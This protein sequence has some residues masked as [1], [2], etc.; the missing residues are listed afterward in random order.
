MNFI[1]DNMLYV[2]FLVILIVL[3]RNKLLA[4]ITIIRNVLSGKPGITPDNVHLFPVLPQALID[5]FAKLGLIGL[6]VEELRAKL[7]AYIDML[8][9]LVPMTPTKLDD[10]VVEVLRAL[11]VKPGFVEILHAFLLTRERVVR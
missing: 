2:V 3:G 10:K 11:I 8:Q 6:P 4:A 5:Q 7:L 1:Q 9:A